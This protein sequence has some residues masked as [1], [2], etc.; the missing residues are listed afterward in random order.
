L[1]VC[2]SFEIIQKIEND[3]E[4]HWAES[5]RPA[6]TVPGVALSHRTGTAHGHV[7]WHGSHSAPTGHGVSQRSRG[8]RQLRLDGRR[9]G[10]SLKQGRVAQP[11]SQGRWRRIALSSGSD[12]V[13]P[14]S[15]DPGR[16]DSAAVAMRQL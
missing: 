1:E 15:G 8:A 12:A 7:A 11:S 6:H 10:A 2:S 16:G 5:A 13:A 3:P 4:P 9:R 14:R